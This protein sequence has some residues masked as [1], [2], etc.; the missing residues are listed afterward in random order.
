MSGSC[1]K[2]PDMNTD[3]TSKYPLVE[4]QIFDFRIEMGRHGNPKTTDEAIESLKRQFDAFGP[5][6]FA[7]NNGLLV[8]GSGEEFAVQFMSFYNELH[9][10][11]Y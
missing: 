2:M 8:N 10:G 3:L 9:P 4:R 11:T 6:Q 5:Y 7:L 1:V